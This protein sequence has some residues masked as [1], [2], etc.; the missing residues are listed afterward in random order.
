M[1]L[2]GN[3]SATR[4]A[5]LGVCFDDRAELRAATHVTHR[6]PDAFVGSMLVA[7][8]TQVAATKEPIQLARFLLTAR[9]H[10]SAQIALVRVRALQI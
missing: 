4:T 10:L 8:A 7:L 6:H 9:A 5:L 1:H 3:G 2:V